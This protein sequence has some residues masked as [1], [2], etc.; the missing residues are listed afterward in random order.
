MSAGSWEEGISIAGRG[1]FFT[2]D[3]EGLKWDSMTAEQVMERLK[4]VSSVNGVVEPR[5]KDFPIPTFSRPRVVKWASWKCWAWWTT[6]GM[7]GKKRV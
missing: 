6:S 7:V 5:T 2:Q 3:V 4:Y 1:C